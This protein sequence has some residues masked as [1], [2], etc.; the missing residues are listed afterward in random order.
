MIYL[1]NNATTGVSPQVLE[2]MCRIANVA[3][4]N[5]GSRHLA[6]RRARQVLEDARDSIAEILQARSEEVIFT[7]GGTE[8]SNLALIGMSAGRIGTVLLPAGEHPATEEPVE[9]LIKTGWTRQIIPMDIRGRLD[10]SFLRDAPLTGVLLAT[11]LLAH[12]ET[13]VIQDLRPLAERCR[14]HG[15]PLHVDAVQAVGKIDVSFRDLPATTLSAAAHKFHGPRGIGILLVRKGTRPV[16]LFRGGHQEWGIR[17]GTEPVM[18]AAGMSL[19]LREWQAERDARTRHVQ[20]LRDRLQQGLLSHCNWAVTNGDQQYRLPNTLN[21]A[22]PGCEAD[23]LLVALDL[24][25]ICCSLGS[26]CASGSNEPSPVL[27]GM[28]LTKEIYLSS[29]R[30]SV[31]MQNTPEEIDDAISIIST[32]VQQLRGRGPEDRG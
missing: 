8:S 3:P 30:L 14:E 13:G 32:T 2:E 22:F 23:T 6:G 17:P 10:Q 9:H 21:I 28:G 7:S 18:L 19:A 29:L 1:D 25:G 5:P 11:A 4:G 15:I 27:V 24:A 20:Q 26:A 12:N 16:P 31:S